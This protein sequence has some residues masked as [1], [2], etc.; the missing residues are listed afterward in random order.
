MYIHS[1]IHI[2]TLANLWYKMAVFGVGTYTIATMPCTKGKSQ[3]HEN[4]Y[5]KWMEDRFS[6]MHNA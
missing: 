3:A 5:E 4:S 1:Y 6:T 2:A